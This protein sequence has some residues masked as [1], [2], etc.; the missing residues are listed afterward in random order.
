MKNKYLE[1]ICC[2]WCKEKLILKN[3]LMNGEEIEFGE[4]ECKKC[5]KYYK[6]ENYI[7]LLL[8]GNEGETK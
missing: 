5:K 6:I 3:E 4:L 1:I 7:P 8:V 2:P